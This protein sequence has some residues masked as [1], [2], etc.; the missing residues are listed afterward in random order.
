MSQRIK[1][2]LI[3]VSEP[4]LIGNEAKYLKECIRDGEI[5]S[6]GKFV[7]R[8]EEAFCEWSGNKYACAVSS[9]T[10]ALEVAMKSLDLDEISM[11]VG[12]IISCFLAAMRAEIEVE[13]HDNIDVV[14]DKLLR[15][16]LFGNR[17][18][19]IGT[20]VVDD[21][22]QYW[23]PNNPVQDVGIY[24]LYANKC[25]TTGEGGMIV[26]NSSSIDKMARSFRNLC[27]SSARFVHFDFGYNFRMS[28]MQAAVGLAQLERIDD[29]MEIKRKN[30]DYYLEY[31]P[32]E[33][34]PE[35]NNDQPW[36]YLIR[37]PYHAGELMDLMEGQ[38]VECRRFFFPLNEQPCI[39][40]EFDYDE[41]IKFPIA[42]D[43]WETAF[44]L[45]SGYNL[46]PQEIQYVCEELRKAIR[47]HKQRK[48][49]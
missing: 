47:L 38:G 29:L 11:P 32:D 49:L 16:H 23:E 28:N 8:F 31:L 6:G 26:T 10:A 44:Y 1:N 41:D 48:G 39:R 45:P 22:S 25:L 21:F 15:C 12:T 3:K 33:C 42:S 7:H 40:Q 9:G 4:L 20:K 37:T 2:T 35:F 24:S 34:T 5:S 30:R 19:S 17:D 14:E 36:M 46:T 13:F 43:L 27:H 18:G